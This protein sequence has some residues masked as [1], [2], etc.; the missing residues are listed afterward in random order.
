L[1]VDLIRELESGKR[2]PKPDNL[3]AFRDFQLK[4]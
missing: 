2:S 3:G 1:V 4:R